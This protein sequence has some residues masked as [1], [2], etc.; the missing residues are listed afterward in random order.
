MFLSMLWIF[1]CQIDN[2]S[3]PKINKTFYDMLR[4]INQGISVMGYIIYLK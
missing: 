2:L 4:F 3:Y 1:I